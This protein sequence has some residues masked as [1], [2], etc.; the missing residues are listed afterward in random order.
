[1]G[2]DDFRSRIAEIF[3]TVFADSEHDQ[4]G[5]KIQGTASQRVRAHEEDLV[6]FLDRQSASLGFLRFHGRAGR[7]VIVAPGNT[8]ELAVKVDP[9]LNLAAEQVRF[10]VGPEIV[11]VSPIDTERF[12]RLLYTPPRP[13]LFEVGYGVV[14]AVG[15]AFEIE[16]SYGATLL[17]VV[18][19]SPMVAI[20]AALILNEEKDPAP[21]IELAK[22]DWEIC[23]VDLH[24]QDRTIDIRRAVKDRKLPSGAVLVHPASELD[25]KTLKVD[26]QTVF[27]T[28]TFRRI[29]AA[30]VPLVLLV[31][32]EPHFGHQ[33]TQ[34]GV[35]S[36]DLNGLHN[37][38]TD[39]ELFEQLTKLGQ[40]FLRERRKITNQFTWRLNQMTNTKPIGGNQCLVEFDNGEARGKIFH[41]IQTA[42]HTIDLQFYI[43]KD[44]SFTEH[45]AVNLI[46]KARQGVAVRLLVDAL[47]A[48]Q[49]L[50]GFKNRILEGLSSEPNIQVVAVD[51]IRTT[52]DLDAILLKQRDH[53][54]LIIIDGALAFVGGR[55]AGDEYY[56]SFR[57]VPVTDWTPADR[58]PWLD[59]HI[60]VQ[61]PLVSDIQQMFIKTWIRNKGD[62]GET[63]LP[64]LSISGEFAA[65]LV[66]HDGI[67]DSNGLAAYEAIIEAA[68][69]HIYVLNDFPVIAS[70]AM[71]LRRAVTRGVTVTFL[72]GNAVARRADHS[73]FKGSLHR[74]LFEYMTKKRFEQLIKNG[75]RVYEYTTPDL[76]T[77]VSRG[78]LVRPYV[79]AKVVTADGMVASIGSANLDATAS[80]WEREANVIVENTDFVREL[81]IKIQQ[82][83]DRS[84]QILLDSDYWLEES[85][86]REIVSRLWPQGIL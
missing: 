27:A 67:S 18:D 11:G 38:I 31:W 32:D 20:D 10:R 52:D 4:A 17:Q 5:E 75:V 9:L 14:R 58:I 71:A 19:E 49:E 61:G 59:A 79:H 16:A 64:E 21:I 68:V 55:N 1:M 78:G 69:H 72:T 44:C 28:T 47:Y 66:I 24:Q 29:R 74:E 42:R 77:I 7:D 50:F 34:E 82:M 40:H 62:A 76:P 30:G 15:S 70:L 57:E 26:F 63:K 51:P 81:E 43:F 85:K 8:I 39:D 83:T 86:Q 37:M 65:R 84:Y 60:E 48:T 6:Q 23:Y 22:R 13:G 46:S 3:R 54:K 41:A 2:K 45:L 33:N 80:Y 73:F 53:R 56:T 12:A 36:T 25:F 35:H